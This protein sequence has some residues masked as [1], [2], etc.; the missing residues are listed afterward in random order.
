MGVL[1]VRAERPSDENWRYRKSF[2]HNNLPLLSD[3]ILSLV[4]ALVSPSVRLAER[5]RFTALACTGLKHESFLAAEQTK[6]SGSKIKA[7]VV[8]L[9]EH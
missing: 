8:R 7:R 6:V 4:Y 3:Q 5:A 1:R 9:P 2:K